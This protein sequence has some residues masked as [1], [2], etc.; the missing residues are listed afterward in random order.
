MLERAASLELEQDCGGVRVRVIN[1]SGHKIPT[2]HIEGR[3][4]WTNVKVYDESDQLV[5]EYGHYDTDT[6]HL[7]EES[8]DIYEMHVGLSELASQVTG[9][10][11][12]VTTHMAL[13]D[14]IVKD[15]RIPPRGF[16]NAAYEAGGAPVVGAV[17]ADEQYWDDTH[18]WIPEDAARVE[19]TVNYQTVTRHYIEAL[20]DGNVTDGWGNALYQLW[21]DTNKGAPI[22]MVSDELTL[23]PF[24]RGD[25]NG[26]GRIA[27]MDY[28][29]FA[30]CETGPSADAPDGCECMDFDGDGD[31]DLL[32]FLSLQM[33]FTSE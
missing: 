18:F 11:A 21:L 5:R 33:A 16:D 10:P 15:T 24:V 6:A 22:P 17:Y 12:G 4:I 29:R 14:T 32:D 26:D 23:T 31:V 8:T 25:V 28:S 9:Y 1:E 2:G 27:L 3:R 7:D 19:V 13:A 20:R 30:A